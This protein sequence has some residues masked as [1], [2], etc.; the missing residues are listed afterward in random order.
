MANATSG[1]PQGSATVTKNIGEWL[2]SIGLAEYADRFTENAID[3]SVIHDLTD[4]D[5]KELGVLLVTAAK[6]YD[7]SQLLIRPLLRP[8]PLSAP[9]RRRRRN[10]VT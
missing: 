10:D 6:F 8:L 5:L 4:Q 2:A 1:Q 9:C 3:L 7:P